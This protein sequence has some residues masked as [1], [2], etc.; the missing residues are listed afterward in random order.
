MVKSFEH[1]FNIGQTIYHATPD[2]D[3]GIIINIQ[4]S[5]KDRT[6]FYKCCFGRKSEDTVWCDELELSEDKIY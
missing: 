3:R 6:V 5:V 1:K 4:Y 2:G